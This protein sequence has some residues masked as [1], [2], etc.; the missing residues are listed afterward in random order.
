MNVNIN[1]LNEAIKRREDR[2]SEIHEALL[3][4]AVPGD[5][6]T[7]QIDPIYVSEVKPFLEEIKKLQ[8]ANTAVWAALEQARQVYANLGKNELVKSLIYSREPD[9]PI[10]ALSLAIASLEKR[11]S[12]AIE[13][14]QRLNSI[15]PTTFMPEIPPEKEEQAGKLREEILTIPKQIEILEG[16][17]KEAQ[18][19]FENLPNPQVL[20]RG[21]M[22]LPQ[23]KK[24][25][26]RV[27]GRV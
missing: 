1:E 23:K 2:I 13:E 25:H 14:L 26:C 20:N 21:F 27:P 15:N 18:K 10:A 16:G 12:E 3:A 19:A 17:Y 22:P 11:R 4:F 24:M 6:L 9:D 8:A 7:Y 5:A